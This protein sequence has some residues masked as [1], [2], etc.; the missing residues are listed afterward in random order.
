MTGFK[1]FDAREFFMGPDT[2][3][4]LGVDLDFGHF[5]FNAEARTVHLPTGGTK[6]GSFNIYEL[7]EKNYL[8]LKLTGR[9]EF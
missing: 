7:T 5:G 8:L 3:F 9:V 2:L 1:Q 4:A 6:N